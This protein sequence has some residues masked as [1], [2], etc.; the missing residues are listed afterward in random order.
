MVPAMTNESLMRKYLLGD[1][2]EEERTRIE[3]EYFADAERFEELVGVENDLID[4]YVRG[5]MS[6]SERRQFEQCYANRPDRRARVD[7]ATA[8]SQAALQETKSIAAH[9]TS[10]WRSVQS[11]FKIQR[12]QLHWALASA[13]V[14]LVGILL[15][16]QNYRLRRELQ[17]A[18]ANANQL[19]LQ[20][21]TLRKQQE[22]LGVQRQH[23]PES[24]QSGQL[25]QLEPPVDLTFRLGSLV[26]GTVG[27]R[28]LVIPQNRPWVRLEMELER[29]EYKTYEAVL[30][31]PEQNREILRG[32]ELQSH[33]IGGRSVVSWRLRS[34]SI[35]SGDYIVRLRGES[36]GGDLENVASYSF[37]AVRE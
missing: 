8:L 12:P 34:K 11:Y 17:G 14:L 4:S 16:L 30:M 36:T 23:A 10:P 3:D 22:G 6:D 32:K 18:Q 19:R 37:R 7:F 33:S 9:K 24:E 28:D 35:Q 26:R 21:D 25:A 20:Q 31:P 27:Q 5:T 1:L 29:D 13:A 15:G 2:P